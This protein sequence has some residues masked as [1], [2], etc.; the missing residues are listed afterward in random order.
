MQTQML[1]G[2]FAVDLIGSD[3]GHHYAPDFDHQNPLAG[4]GG[5]WNLVER[6]Y[7]AVVELYRIGD[8]VMLHS[9]HPTWTSHDPTVRRGLP[10]HAE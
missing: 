3:Q 7:H 1:E 6:P 8:R 2:Q 4:P 5:R 10:G 9:M